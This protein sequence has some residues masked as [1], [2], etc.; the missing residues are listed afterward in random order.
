MAKA[1]FVVSIVGKSM[2][3]PLKCNISIGRA[4]PWASADYGQEPV[5]GCGLG[6]SRETFRDGLGRELVSPWRT[7]PL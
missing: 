5:R 4:G 1:H 2:F 6:V 3:F 7:R